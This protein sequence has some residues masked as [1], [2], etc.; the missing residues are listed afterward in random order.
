MLINWFKKYDNRPK[1]KIKPT[2][3]DIIIDAISFVLL[4]LMGLMI[5]QNYSDLPNSIPTHFGIVGAV[6]EYGRKQMIWLL[7]G[8]GFIAFVGMA[9]LNKFPHK[10][11]YLVNIT[12]QNAKQQYTIGTRI[13]RFTNLF[14]MAV[15]FYISNKT[16]N[17]AL[18]KSPPSLEVWFAP[19]ILSVII[20]GI[21]VIVITSVLKK[22]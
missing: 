10:F 5:F 18:H 12:Q 7:P 4:L 11:N 13:V 6:D 17:I 9:I 14:V 8:I 2:A 15:F 16:L 21:I 20:V 1:L 3:F 22:I 19:T